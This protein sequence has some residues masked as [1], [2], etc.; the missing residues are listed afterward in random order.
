MKNIFKKK[1]VYILLIAILVSS[2]S[3]LYSK[4][5]DKIEE[6]NI[7]MSS[8]DI[9]LQTYEFGDLSEIDDSAEI[10]LS[11]DNPYVANIAYSHYVKH[12]EFE[13][14]GH[15]QYT[16][17]FRFQKS[18]YIELKLDSE[19]I[20]D[21]EFYFVWVTALRA[22]TANITMTIDQNGVI[23]KRIYHVTVAGSKP[24]IKKLK[25]GN[26]ILDNGSNYFEIWYLTRFAEITLSCNKDNAF[27]FVASGCPGGISDTLT[28][29]K[30]EVTLVN[31]GDWE[32]FSLKPLKTGKFKIYVKVEQD[33]YVVKKTFNLQVV[34]YKN[35]LKSFQIGN[36]D[37]AKYYNKDD[38]AA[39]WNDVLSKKLCL[40]TQGGKKFSI[41]MKKGYKLVSMRYYPSKC[42]SST[43]SKTLKKSAKK[44][45]KDFGEL[46]ICYKDMYG[47]K[48]YLVLDV[49]DTV[50]RDD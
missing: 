48:R 37:Y 47:Y 22:G 19:S 32:D 34:K 1:F 13:E 9:Y 21:G 7:E 30:K 49:G 18:Q 14:P 39:D 8:R 31:S 15:T 3:V 20:P 11:S 38:T 41:K 43:P 16:D 5:E 40:Y 46:Y 28:I 6:Y 50:C 36:K 4:A 33:G 44:L 35:P 26:I 17:Y 25:Y 10:T 42:Y 23:S 29:G 45:P 27:K 24:S 2:T 12:G